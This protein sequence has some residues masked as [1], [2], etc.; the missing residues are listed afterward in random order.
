MPLQRD[1]DANGRGLG[2]GV[3]AAQPPDVVGGDAG[4]FGGVLGRV[5]RR[6]FFEF[7]E[8][9]RVS[10]DIVAI[11]QIVGND[12]MNH[13]H[14]QRAVGAGLRGQM[15]V[16]LL[17]G[18]GFVGVDHHHLGAVFPRLVD[19]MPV[20]QVGAD[21][22]AGPD[23][24]VFRLGEAFRIDAAGGPDR[25]QPGGGRTARAESFFQHARAQLVEKRVADGQALKGALV[26]Q[27]V[28]GKNRFRAVLVDEGGPAGLD[29]VQRL[30]PGNPLEPARAFRPHA[31]QRIQH[32]LRIVVMVVEILELGA[33]AAPRERMIG[34]A[35][36]ID[37]PVVFDF[38]EHRAG[39]R[40]I[41]GAGAENGSFLAGSR[42]VL[43]PV[44]CRYVNSDQD[45]TWES[46]YSISVAYIS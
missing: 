26:A 35:A 29:L 33:K 8:S 18:A 43:P 10:G 38:V 17:G 23:N 7:L 22:I 37:Q 6:S 20:M 12:L 16:G 13:R 9:D 46:A 14:G 27:V 5:A 24:D 41:V 32:A 2:R 34:I 44:N 31:A 1:A 40:A 25:E 42:H 19:D 39:V 45:E 4:D 28:V 21:R 11:Q 36:H 30:V 15:P 3:F